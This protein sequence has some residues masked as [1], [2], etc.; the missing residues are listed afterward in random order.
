[1]LNKTNENNNNK[2]ARKVEWYFEELLQVEQLQNVFSNLYIC[3]N[4]FE[5]EL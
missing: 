3:F 1:M 4:L 5:K 2:K